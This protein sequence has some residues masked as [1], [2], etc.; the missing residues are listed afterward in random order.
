MSRW[1]LPVR[2]PWSLVFMVLVVAGVAARL[3]TIDKS[4]SPT[5]IKRAVDGARLLVQ[6]STSG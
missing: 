1:Q 4:S 3:A 5:L 6:G 2:R